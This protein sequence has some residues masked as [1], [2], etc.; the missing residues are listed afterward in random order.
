MKALEVNTDYSKSVKQCRGLLMSLGLGP[1][2]SVSCCVYMNVKCKNKFILSLPILKMGNAP[3]WAPK[4]KV[5]VLNMYMDVKCKYKIKKIF[6]CYKYTMI[7]LRQ[8]RKH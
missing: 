1:G 8:Q 5:R 4:D 2:C 6:R 7:Y 3:P